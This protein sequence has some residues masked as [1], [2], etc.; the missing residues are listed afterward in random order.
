MQ[1]E[2]ASLVRSLLLSIDRPPGR[3]CRQWH[4]GQSPGRIPRAAPACRAV[5]VARWAF[6]ELFDGADDGA[7]ADESV[8]RCALLLAHK[9]RSPVWDGVRRRRPAHTL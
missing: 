4:R 1:K 7:S 2:V 6:S 8:V 5:L 3:F 9:D